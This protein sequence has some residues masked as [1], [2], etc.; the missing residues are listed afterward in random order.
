MLNLSHGLGS[1]NDHL[2]VYLSHWCINQWWL[3][4]L[5]YGEQVLYHHSVCLCT[6]YIS[7]RDCWHGPVSLFAPL[8]FKPF[9][10]S[11][12]TLRL[13]QQDILLTPVKWQ[14]LSS[15][16]MCGGLA[17]EQSTGRAGWESVGRVSHSQRDSQLEGVLC[18]HVKRLL[19]PLTALRQE[20]GQ[21]C[22]DREA[23]T[24]SAA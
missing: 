6:A 24:D 2:R 20:T 21:G 23:E 16:I 9:S 19:A 12:S 5:C 15:I 7:S 11:L 17:K 8:C 13:P 4:W 10:D 22:R 14:H 3:L 18:P 1:T